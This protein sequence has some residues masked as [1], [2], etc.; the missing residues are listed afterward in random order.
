MKKTLEERFWGRVNKAPGQGP[1]GTCWMWT[2][3]T[4]H[5]APIIKINGKDKRATRVAYGLTKGP[6]PKGNRIIQKCKQPL[7]VRHV[8][9]YLSM[10]YVMESSRERL[11]KMYLEPRDEFE[12]RA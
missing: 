6:L 10:A 5:G 12:V 11:H 2:G 9:V 1:R 8:D 3:G 4:S 7:C